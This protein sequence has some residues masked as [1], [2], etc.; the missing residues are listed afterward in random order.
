MI[1][2]G[3]RLLGRSLSDAV[4]F[5]RNPILLAGL[6]SI[7]VMVCSAIWSLCRGA[8]AAFSSS[9]ASASGMTAC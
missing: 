8:A 2:E 7:G 3:D 1:Q 9:A 4:A 6:M 5:M